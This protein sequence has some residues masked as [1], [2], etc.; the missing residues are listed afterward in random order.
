MIKWLIVI[1]AGFLLVV[2][3]IGAYLGPNDLRGCKATPSGHAPCQA[4]DAI[5]AVSGGD[6]SARAAGA[7]ALFQNGWGNVLIFSGAAS[8]PSS[9]SNATVMKRQALA[10]GV[11]ASKIFVDT[12]SMTTEQNAANVH[13]IF[14][15]HNIHSV[16]LVTSAYHQRRAYL[17]FTKFNPGVS[18]R[19]S[20]VP[21]DDQWSNLWWLTPTGWWL[22]LSELVKIV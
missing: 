16:I 10:A 20:P 14:E 12:T 8:D 5:V 1:I 3:A 22:A 18:V 9:P 7:I 6:T 2:L 15:T 4:A 13:T 21:Q 17:E 19:N 11:P